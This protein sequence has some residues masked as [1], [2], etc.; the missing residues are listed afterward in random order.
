MKLLFSKDDKIREVFTS[1]KKI[2]LKKHHTDLNNTQTLRM[3]ADIKPFQKVDMKR[4]EQL[5][6]KS[7][8]FNLTTKRYSYTELKQL[9]KQNFI[10]LQLDCLIYMEKWYHWIS[11]T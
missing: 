11:N 3:K 9:L 7:N 2:D 5:I 4:I 8:Q 1:E 6:N 10:T